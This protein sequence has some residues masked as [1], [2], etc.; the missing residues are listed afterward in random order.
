MAVG[1]GYGQPYV[2]GDDVQTPG[3]SGGGNCVGIPRLSVGEDGFQVVEFLQTS[4]PA[5]DAPDG[6]PVSHGYLKVG[7]RPAHEV[8]AAILLADEQEQDLS[9]DQR[10]A[11][12]LGDELAREAPYDAGE[13]A[14]AGHAFR[15]GD[16]H[17]RLGVDELAHLETW[18]LEDLAKGILTPAHLALRTTVSKSFPEEIAV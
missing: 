16:F 8:A 14:A 10:V 3:I 13:V 2:V 15:T 5:E 6:A 1:E 11:F 4:V 12:V 18:K 7:E 17:D 9:D